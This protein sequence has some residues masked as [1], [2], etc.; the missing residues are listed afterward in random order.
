MAK[1]RRK[2]PMSSAIRIGVSGWS[3]PSWRGRVFPDPKPRAFHPLEF[4]SRSLDLVEIDLTE[5]ECLRPEIARVW[6]RKISKNS[7]FLFTAKM[8]TR[9]THD[10]ILSP[11]EVRAW[12]QGV[13]PIQEAGRLGAVL[14]HFPRS[15]RYTAENRAFLISL[16]RTFHEFPLAAEMVH[17]S[18][19]MD[20]AIG[21]F[22][23]YHIGFVNIDQPPHA[24][25]MP[26]TSFLTSSIG[27]VRL[28][29]KVDG[30]KYLYGTEELQRW[31]TKVER[32]SV[33]STNTFVVFANDAGG[34]AV[35]NAKQFAV[36]NSARVPVPERRRPASDHIQP[37]LFSGSSSK[38]VA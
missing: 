31:H 24:R 23:D 3:H 17:E 2:E 36:A 9:F 37:M 1:I 28:R 13:F 22:I 19:M 15:F 34:R 5:R 10:R 11:D 33:Y 29:G 25:A 35:V 30:G 32:V 12:K 27:Y 21:T 20:E 38:A 4:L 6:V 26:P 16:R 8:H 7:H 18:W 14:M